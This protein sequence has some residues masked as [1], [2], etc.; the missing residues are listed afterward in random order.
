M[1]TLKWMINADASFDDNKCTQF[2]F[3]KLLW[4]APLAA[5]RQ[6]FIS[7]E[8]EFITINMKFDNSKQI[9]ILEEHKYK[10]DKTAKIKEKRKLLFGD[11]VTAQNFVY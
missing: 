11:L 6:V 9:E 10:T 3:K 7:R 8:N 1:L 5:L 2:K 4:R